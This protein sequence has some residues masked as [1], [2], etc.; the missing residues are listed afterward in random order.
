MLFKCEKT[1]LAFCAVPTSK[2]ANLL[3][4]F[5]SF[6]DSISLSS[7]PSTSIFN[8][9]FVSSISKNLTVFTFI[10]LI[11]PYGF[12]ALP[13]KLEVELSITFVNLIFVFFVKTAFLTN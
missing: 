4:Q 10:V 5:F 9:S 8:M 7:T 1:F 12:F 11:G 13:I 3:F 6:V 2:I